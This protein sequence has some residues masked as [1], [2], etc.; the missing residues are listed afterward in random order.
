MKNHRTKP[1]AGSG[2]RT[3]GGALLGVLLI[4]TAC[5][6]DVAPEPPAADTSTDLQTYVPAAFGS[7]IVRHGVC[8]AVGTPLW[9]ESRTVEDWGLVVPLYT[10]AIPE[11]WE[12]M[13]IATVDHS[14][15]LYAAIILSPLEKGE[16]FHEYGLSLDGYLRYA[17][18][19]SEQ[20]HLT[21][22]APND[23]VRY[24]RLFERPQP[25]RSMVWDPRE[26]SHTSS[27]TET[28][29]VGVPFAP[30]EPSWSEPLEPSNGGGTGSSDSGS[31][32]GGS[33]SGISTNPDSGEDETPEF[34][35]PD[36]DPCVQAAS[37]NNKNQAQKN[38]ASLKG[39]LHPKKEYGYLS[40]EKGWMMGRIQ[41]GTASSVPMDLQKSRKYSGM[42]HTHLAGDVCAISPGDI[43]SI[44]QMLRDGK[45]HNPTSFTFT[46]L[47]TDHAFTLTV[48]DTDV[49]MDFCHTYKLHEAVQ[50]PKTGEVKVT[51]LDDA[52]LKFFYSNGI[53][54]E[55]EQEQRTK[56][57]DQFTDMFIKFFNESN[58]GLSAIKGVYNDKGEPRWQAM[59]VHPDGTI[60]PLCP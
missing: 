45:M 20:R 23:S 38:Y 44:Y 8:N 28:T 41:E 18:C 54:V 55:L 27:I 3:A 26:N 46:V 37:M 1:R 2:W 10:T 13:L 14:D 25:G 17:I 49:F 51:E 53:N 12:A 29:V 30:P 43:Y 59:E 42:A 50:D 56:T 11:T 22:Y 16:E 15:T 31:W 24:T 34:P 7:R 5:T 48:K 60:S 40:D 6:R 33:G 9:S 36:G 58:S 57:A 32:W 19:Y 47:L 35:N 4:V 52:M 21:W 39:K